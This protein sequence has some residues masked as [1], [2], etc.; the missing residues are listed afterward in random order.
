MENMNPARYEQFD[1]ESLYLQLLGRRSVTIWKFPGLLMFLIITVAVVC[2]ISS[3]T[4]F[5]IML[6][7]PVLIISWIMTKY[8]YYIPDTFHKDKESGI[9]SLMYCSTIPTFEIMRDLLSHYKPMSWWNVL[10]VGVAGISLVHYIDPG[11]SSIPFAWSLV[12][13]L[14]WLLAGCGI[15]LAFLPAWVYRSGIVFVVYC[16]MAVISIW[17]VKQAWG[18]S[19]VTYF[20]RSFYKLESYLFILLIINILLGVVSYI[21]WLIIPEFAELQRKGVLK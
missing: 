17:L 3:L 9:I 12:F 10:I 13:I 8:L 2:I 19:F 11:S 15:L 16:I 20:G 6:A 4:T 14:W 5:S 18:W 7:I 1:I 21:I